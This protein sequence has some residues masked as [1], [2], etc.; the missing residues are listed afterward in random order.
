MK[1]GV[2]QGSVSRPL[3]FP[4]VPKALSQEYTSGLPWEVL[5]VDDLI[6]VADSEEEV[7]QIK[8]VKAWS[9]GKRC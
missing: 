6:L 8:K 9:G 4:I 1:V 2:Y 3:L 7:M 5:Y